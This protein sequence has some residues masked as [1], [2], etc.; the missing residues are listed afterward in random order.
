MYEFSSSTLPPSNPK[1]TC[2]Q[3][4][5]YV[6]LLGYLFLYF[7]EVFYLSALWLFAINKQTGD[8]FM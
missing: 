1:S 8:V 2:F 7:F 4:Q 5:I 3:L 6:Y